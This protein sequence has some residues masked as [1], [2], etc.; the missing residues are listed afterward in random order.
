MKIVEAIFGKMKILNFFFCEPPTL[1]FECRSK[2]KKRAIDSCKGTLDIECERDW[3][4]GLGATLGGGHKIK[5]IFLVSTIFINFC[6]VIV[7]SNL[8]NMALL[9]FP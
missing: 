9:A 4:V 5:N 3:L 7:H 2:T 6:G 8:N 1:N